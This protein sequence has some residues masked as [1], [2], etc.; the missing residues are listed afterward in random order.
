MVANS[1]AN[2]AILA[3]ADATSGSLNFN[4]N[5]VV[6]LAKSGSN[7]DARIGT[8]SSSATFGQD[9]T[10]VRASTVSDGVTA[11]DTDEWTNYASDT[12]DLPGRPHDGRQ[13]RVADGV[14]GGRRR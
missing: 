1:S 14:R 10:K 13:R 5:D 6:A 3:E 12:V 2:A 4:G 11:Y 7:I 9:V 8:I